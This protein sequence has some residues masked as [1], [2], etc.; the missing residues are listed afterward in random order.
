M[1][2]HSCVRTLNIY[3]LNDRGST[4]SCESQ[5]ALCAL[6]WPAGGKGLM[7]LQVATEILECAYFCLLAFLCLDVMY[8][9]RL[10]SVYHL[11]RDTKCPG[12][13]IAF[14]SPLFSLLSAFDATKGSQKIISIFFISLRSFY[15]YVTKL[16][17]RCWYPNHVVA[18]SLDR[19]LHH[20]WLQNGGDRR[21]VDITQIKGRV[22]SGQPV[23]GAKTSLK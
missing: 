11:N 3:K 9:G 12:A 21:V 14:L 6:M 16:I 1:G 20:C 7:N 15:H 22:R 4:P 17:E 8:L 23:R 13:F 19:W 2:R 10:K 5:P 18:I